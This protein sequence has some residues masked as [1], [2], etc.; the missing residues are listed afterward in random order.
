MF[1]RGELVGTCRDEADTGETAL[2]DAGMARLEHHPLG[3]CRGKRKYEP[4]RAKARRQHQRRHDRHALGRGRFGDIEIGRDH[5][6]GTRDHHGERHRHPHGEEWYRSGI[7]RG[8]AES[9]DQP[10][11]R[12]ARRN[13]QGEA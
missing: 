5:R 2:E 1:E 12:C 4:H 3:E 11:E 6:S 10:F 7:G 9:A 13:P 8:P